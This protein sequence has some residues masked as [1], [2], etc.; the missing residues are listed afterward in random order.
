[1]RVVINLKT[2]RLHKTEVGTP[3]WTDLIP[4]EK[5]YSQPW[6]HWQPVALEATR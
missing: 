5:I 4:N 3:T 6:L 1:M 2:S